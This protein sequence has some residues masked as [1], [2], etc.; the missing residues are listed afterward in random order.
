MQN[1]DNNDRYF[2]SK[3]ETELENI[4]K[5]YTNL[6]NSSREFDE[7]VKEQRKMDVD[8]N[9]LSD[10]INKICEEKSIKTLEISLNEGAED[11]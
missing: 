9:K 3:N 8:L 10:K 4:D 6:F 7:F 2:T 1:Q 5:T 11:E